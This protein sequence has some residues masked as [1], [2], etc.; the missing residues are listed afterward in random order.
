MYIGC[1]IYEI[2]MHGL[3]DASHI[4]IGI[5]YKKTLV[6]IN[7]ILFFTIYVYMYHVTQDFSTAGE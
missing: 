4:A 3:A 1:I 7:L 6:S 5:A 2:N